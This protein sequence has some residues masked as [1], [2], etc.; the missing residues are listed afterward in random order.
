[1]STKLINAVAR[2]LTDRMDDLD[3]DGSSGDA[4]NELI[5]TKSYVPR[6]VYEYAHYDDSIVRDAYLVVGLRSHS[7][8]TSFTGNKYQIW[9]QFKANSLGTLAKPSTTM[10]FNPTVTLLN[11]GDDVIPDSMGTDIDYT[12]YF[13]LENIGDELQGN[14]GGVYD[15]RSIAK[16]WSITLKQIIDGN[17]AELH[18]NNIITNWQVTTVPAS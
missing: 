13:K 16:Y 8:I 2:N 5:V 10:V 3:G 11:S 17:V 9:V 7:Q 12:Y 18:E 4:S 1:M 14:S 6:Y 15:Y